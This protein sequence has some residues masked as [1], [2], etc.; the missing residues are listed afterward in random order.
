MKQQQ[1]E[2]RHKEDWDYLDNILSFDHKDLDQR[3]PLLYRQLCHQLALAK[4]RR[5]SPQL[6]NRLNR[7]VLSAHH[8]FYQHNNNYQYLWLRFLVIDFPTTLRANSKYVLWALALF[9]VPGLIMA[10]GC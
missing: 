9:L 4:H 6:I 3:F 2:K 10:I 1:F 7:L 5:Y 8:R